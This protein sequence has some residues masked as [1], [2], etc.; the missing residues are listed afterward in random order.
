MGDIF[1][2]AGPFFGTAGLLLLTLCFA[3][4]Q[5]LVTAELSCAYPG[6]AG[7]SIW[8]QEA[9]GDFWG[10]QE[11]YWQW[12]SGVIDTAVYPVLIC[13]TVLQIMGRSG[14]G[15]T[16]VWLWRFLTTTLLSLPTF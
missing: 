5:C 6:N 9:F 13:D 7:Y 8:V 14:A 16:E 15:V 10:A 4:P 2:S 3:V 12:V 11:C 1:S